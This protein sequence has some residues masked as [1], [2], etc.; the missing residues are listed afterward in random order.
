MSTGNY[1]R[2]AELWSAVCF[3]FSRTGWKFIDS[4]QI[5]NLV[6]CYRELGNFTALIDC[7]ICLIKNAMFFTPGQVSNYSQ[8]LISCIRKVAEPILKKECV[9]FRI[10]TMN[11]VD[12]ISDLDSVLIHLQIHSMVKEEFHFDRISVKLNSGNSVDLVC[13]IEKSVLSFG[14]NTITLKAHVIAF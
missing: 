9:I 2:A 10:G 7:Y 8:E 6:T 5:E 12:P 13:D 11:L 14:Q 3:K 1:S 4:L